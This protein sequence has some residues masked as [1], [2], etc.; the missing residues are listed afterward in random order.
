[1]EFY[2][3]GFGG[4]KSVLIAFFL[5]VRIFVVASYNRQIL[6]ISCELYDFMVWWLW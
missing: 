4:C 2:S 3:D 5:N 1:L 6:I